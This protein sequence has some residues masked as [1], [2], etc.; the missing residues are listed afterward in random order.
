MN[1][2]F[3]IEFMVG[4][5]WVLLGWGG[6]VRPLG[7]F[8]RVLLSQILRQMLTIFHDYGEDVYCTV[9]VCVCVCVLTGL[10]NQSV[11]PNHEVMG[12]QDSVSNCSIP[13]ICHLLL[14]NFPC[15]SWYS[16]LRHRYHTSSSAHL[17]VPCLR[18]SIYIYHRRSFSHL[19]VFRLCTS[20]PTTQPVLPL[21]SGSVSY[22]VPISSPTL[23][24]LA[25]CEFSRVS[26]SVFS[27][28][29]WRHH[30]SLLRPHPLYHVSLANTSNKERS[31]IVLLCG[32]NVLYGRGG[33]LGS[34]PLFPRYK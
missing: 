29:S 15:P 21:S 8:Q 27:V 22:C 10:R 26:W 5:G 19:G 2:Q 11:W 25:S 28:A 18:P 33:L 34:E 1:F 24:P 17:G 4:D 3:G 31:G 7:I 6:L 16:N 23:L 13:R 30:I 20:I 14:C 32:G 9:C 12:F